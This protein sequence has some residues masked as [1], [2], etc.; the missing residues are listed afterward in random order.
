MSNIYFGSKVKIH[1]KKRRGNSEECLTLSQVRFFG[2]KPVTAFSRK[3]VN[4]LKEQFKQ[5]RLNIKT[6]YGIRKRKTVCH[7]KKK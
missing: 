3:R 6:A 1:K 4:R 2:L 5:E 7:C